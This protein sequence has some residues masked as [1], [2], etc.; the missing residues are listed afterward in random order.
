MNNLATKL[1]REN[2]NRPVAPEDL[3]G[4]GFAYL[5]NGQ[6]ELEKNSQ[7]YICH[8]LSDKTLSLRKILPGMSLNNNSGFYQTSIAETVVSV[9]QLKAIITA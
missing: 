1:Y 9:A 7:R 4:Y 3:I 6:Y 8:F 5:E 2:E